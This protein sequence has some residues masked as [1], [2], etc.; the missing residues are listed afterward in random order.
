M[1]AV[2]QAQEPSAKYITQREPTL[3]RGFD[4]L[5]TAPG[6]VSGLRELILKLAVQGKLTEQNSSDELANVLLSKI[7]QQREV[8]ALTGRKKREA[9]RVTITC[10]EAPYSTPEG[11]IWVR[12]CDLVTKIGAGSTPLGGRETYVP[13]GVKFLRSQNVWNNGL[14]LDDVAFI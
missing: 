6:G 10:D 7:Q 13:S 8:T 1:N 14:A 9:P 2:L 4:L 5:A 12:L 3:V 11:W